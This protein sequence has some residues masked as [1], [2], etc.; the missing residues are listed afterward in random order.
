MVS[1]FSVCFLSI[2]CPITRH[3]FDTDEND[4]RRRKEDKVNGDKAAIA[5]I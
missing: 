1:V 5:D 2:A 3:R 4:E